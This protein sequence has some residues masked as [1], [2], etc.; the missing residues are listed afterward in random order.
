[1]WTYREERQQFYLHQYLIQQP[2]LNYKNPLMKEYMF[3]NIKYWMDL[4]VDGFR[5][6]AVT[7]LIEDERYLDEP[8]DPTT[9]YKNLI[10]TLNYHATSHFRREKSSLRIVGSE[11]SY[12]QSRNLSF[13]SVTEPEVSIPGSMNRGWIMG[14]GFIHILHI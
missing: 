11:Q 7:K 9:G 12:A 10:K 14:P 8:Q 4:G 6:D 5:F 13:F 2:D 3:D 1:M